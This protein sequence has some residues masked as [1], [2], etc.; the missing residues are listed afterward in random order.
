M[1]T[2]QIKHAKTISPALQNQNHDVPTA[3]HYG[4][5]GTYNKVASRYYFPGM[6]KYIAEYVKNCPDCN[7]YKPSNQKPTGLLR[8]PVYAQRF[9]TLDID[10]FGP[11]PETSSGK[12]WIFLV[13][14]TSTKWVELFALKEA[15]S[16]NC[17]K[18]L[19]EEVFLRY[20]LPRRLIS[21]NG[22]QFISAVMQ[23]TC[24][25]L[26]IK[27]DLIPVY[28]SQ[29]NPS[30]RKNRDLKPRLAILVR[31][32]HDSW[33]EKLPMIR[34][35]LNTAKCETTNHTAAFL[36]FGRELRTTDDVTHDLRALIDNDNF[37]D[38]ITPYLKRFSRLTTEIKDHVE[39]KQDK[40]KMYYD[41]RRRQ[42]FYTPGDQ[43]W[44][45]LH[46]ISKSQNKKSRKFMPK[47][48]GPYLVITNRSP[49]TYDIAD[50]AKPDEVLGTY[51]SSAL[52][53][54]E[55]PVSRDSG[56]I[57]PLRRRGRPK[58]YSADSSPRR[59]T[60]QRGSL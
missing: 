53:A 21:D 26:G 51:H 55:L 60:S 24:N 41:R 48:E 8:T 20:G 2:S 44:V 58:K 7:R 34:F 56:T 36:Q 22:P 45:T 4:A 47:R 49:T 11:L 57:V 27:Q 23:Q 18:T 32:E 14:D 12:K 38:E 31:D 13:E 54:Y 42:A 19:V 25:F 3:G 35:A 16:V 39:Q 28:H 30:E 17:A 46:P 59:R 37:V 40:R 5:E 9:E 1:N 10:L 50:P 43:V 52:R 6:R 29:A 15:T 33:E